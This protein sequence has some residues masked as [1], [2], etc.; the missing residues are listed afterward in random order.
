MTH[1]EPLHAAAQ[2]LRTARAE[3]RPIAPVSTRFDLAG[4]DAAYAVAEINI[5][6]A[7]AEGRRVLGKKVGLT[8]R[9]VQQQLGVSQPDFGILLDD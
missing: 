2:A 8:S 6:A 7:I 1:T 3:R 9:A 5:Q 4:I